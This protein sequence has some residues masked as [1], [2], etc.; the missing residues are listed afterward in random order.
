[1]PISDST[2]IVLRTALPTTWSV[3]DRIGRTLKLSDIELADMLS[4]TGIEF[5]KFK[6]TKKDVSVDKLFSLAGRLN[7]SFDSIMS[8]RVD[9]QALQQHYLGNKTHLPERYQKAALGRRRTTLFVLNY[10]EENFGWEARLAILNHF[11]LNEAIFADPDEPIGFHFSADL[12]DFLYK[13][14][15][16]QDAIAQIG[17]QSFL[18]TNTAQV[19]QEL[20]EC[21]S[22]AELYEKMCMVLVPKYFEKSFI[23]KIIRTGKNHCVLTAKPNPLLKELLKQKVIGNP[24]TAMIRVGLAAAYPTILGLPPAKV[25][26]TASIY[27]GDCDIRYEIDFTLAQ[28]M[29]TAN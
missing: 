7:L 20:E 17:L 15:L 12:C 10:I 6:A 5:Q 28:S 19:K 14:K 26:Q 18:S 21:T 13:Y 25:K 3:V 2:G 4:M 11:Q 1:M 22:V 23:Y 24:A 8:G 16:G 29:F 27:Q 9:Y